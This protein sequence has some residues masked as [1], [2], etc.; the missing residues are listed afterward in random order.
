MRRSGKGSEVLHCLLRAR[1]RVARVATDPTPDALGGW[2]PR[3]LILRQFPPIT[4][5]ISY[6]V[7]L[8]RGGWQWTYQVLGPRCTEVLDLSVEVPL[9][10]I[11]ETRW[12]DLWG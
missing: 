7:I 9:P 12:Q 2:R 10:F 11:G 5:T 6:G 4:I 8:E 1:P 3:L